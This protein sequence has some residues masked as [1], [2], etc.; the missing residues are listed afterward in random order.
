MTQWGRNRAVFNSD[1]AA[2]IIEILTKISLKPIAQMIAAL[3]N[4]DIMDAPQRWLPVW[5]PLKLNVDYASTLGIFTDKTAERLSSFRSVK[6]EY[7]FARL[8]PR[9]CAVQ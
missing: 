8:F 7:A 9:I 5:P 6:V 1:A 3:V 4:L 2:P